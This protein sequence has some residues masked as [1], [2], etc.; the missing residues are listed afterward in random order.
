[1]KIIISTK[2]SKLQGKIIWGNSEHKAF[3]PLL[4]YCYLPLMYRYLTFSI[5]IKR[6]N[7]STSQTLFAT[8]R[9][10]W[11][12][13]IIQNTADNRKLQVSPVYSFTKVIHSQTCKINTGGQITKI[14]L[15][16]FKIKFLFLNVLLWLMFFFKY[17]R[18]YPVYIMVL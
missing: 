13:A 15:K 5:I 11:V 7:K 10:Y 8:D 1:M 14:K 2:S 17:Q 18:N 9:D 6:R 3:I 4:T 16:L 12:R